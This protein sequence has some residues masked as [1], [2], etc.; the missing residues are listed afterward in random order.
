M[1]DNQKTITFV[2]VGAV[3]LLVGFAPW[4]ST[5][6]RPTAEDE[7]GRKLFEGFENARS[8][9]SMEIIE[10]DED[11][12]TIKPFKVAQVNGIWVIPSHQE[13]PADAKEHLAAAATALIDVEKLGVAGDSPGEHELFGVI[14][15]DISKLK[16]GTTGVGERVIMKDAKDNTLADVIIGKEVKDQPGVR[17]VRVTGKDP[18]YRVK[19]ST[20]KFSTK[21]EDWIEK[22]LLKLNTFDIREVDLNDYTLQQGID[23]QGRPGIGQVKAS[24]MKL[25]YDDAKSTW[26]LADFVEYEKNKPKSSKLK[27]E[28]ELN[29][30][31]L[32]DLRSALDDLKIVN[33]AR[34]PKG[35]SGDLSISAEMAN[36]P[37]AL[38]ELENSLMRRGF[39]PVAIDGGKLSVLSTDGEVIC[40]LKDGVDYI[41][42]FGQVAAGADS[43]KKQD[44][45]SGADRYVMITAQLDESAIPKPEL[46][47]LPSDEEKPAD[48]EK[49]SETKV[50]EKKPDA[51][52]TGAPKPGEKKPADKKPAD[53]KPADKKPAVANA[54][55]KK[56]EL[57][58]EEEAAK[59]AEL[60]ENRD[61]IEKANKRKQDEY[62]EKVKKAQEKVDELN[63]RFA[64]WYYV[65]SDDVYK[66][67]HL[68]RVDVVKKKEAKAGEGD[69]TGDFKELNK[70]DLNKKK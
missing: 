69:T 15:P 7:Q 2:I 12:S 17:F 67:I 4:R 20:D 35:L 63:A 6:I 32:N 46:E 3:A 50:D 26:T 42:R 16:P 19:M 23:R 61:R 1:N 11:N 38:D 53:K 55:E 27:E 29:A 33:I 70:S 31:K 48:D 62:D 13:Y 41:V 28:E 59:K 30:E 57:T 8:A 60:E 22:D 25:T 18:I 14:A 21:F 36:D 51:K 47:P 43:G 49:E 68:T 58:P 44:E 40:K 9:A 45:K 65:I 54:E 64:D 34:K 52:K 56:P 39:F 37:A 10:F 24:E 5:S 66:K